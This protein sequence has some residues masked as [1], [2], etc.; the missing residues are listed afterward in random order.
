VR[1]N[2]IRAPILVETAGARRRIVSGWGR[3]LHRPQGE[4]VPC[5]QLPPALSAEASWDVF[6]KDNDAFNVMEIAR[7]LGKLSALPGLGEDRIAAEKL[8]LLGVHSS[9][10]LVRRHL[11][12]LSLSP[13]A[14]KFIEEEGLP[15]K[16]TL[17]LF[18]LHGE[19]LDLI[20]E[21][22]KRFSFTL[23]ELSEFLEMVDEISQRDRVSAAQVL[24][25][26]GAGSAQA[27]KEALRRALRE[28]RYP[29]LSRYRERL[30][31]LS[32]AVAFSVP[33]RI[34]WDAR[35]ERPGIR[36]AAD[37]VEAGA[38]EV[39]ARELEANRRQL[40]GF[41]DVL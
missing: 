2:G 19:D 18:K 15:L 34:D 35:L 1:E 3:W 29:E 37:L 10:D 36:L 12:L 40:E 6:L 30:D 11:R 31:A 4:P 23:N 27:E 26:A 41:F 16:R 8:P 17:M 28:R 22:A 20:L 13:A 24:A 7:V 38:V 9:R 25:D 39:F 21:Q 33:V 14:Q 5:F 32:K